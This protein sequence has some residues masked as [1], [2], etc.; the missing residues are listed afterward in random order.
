MR[1][2]SIKARHFE[3]FLTLM[4]S[5]NLSEAA[6]KLSISQPGVS[7]AIR[8]L[9]EE[10]GAPLF[11]RVKGR[12]RPTA[13][14]KELLPYAQRA[15]G[16]LDIARRI[17]Y[18]LKSGSTTQVTLA[19]SAPFLT[20]IV[21]AAIERLCK[22][23]GDV[24]IEV[25][26]ETTSNVLALVSN[27]DVDIGLSMAPMQTTDAR[28]IEKCRAQQISDSEMVVV[29]RADHPLASRSTIRP[30]DLRDVPVVGLPDDSPNMLHLRAAF[31][32]AHVAVRIPVV[33][34]NSIGVCALVQ[35]NV[36]VGF[37]NPL[38]LA[39]DLFP[40]LVARPFRPRVSLRTFIY[41]S[42]YQPLTPAAALLAKHV[43][44]VVRGIVAARRA[45]SER[46]MAERRAK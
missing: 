9:E 22:E 16:Q 42:A 23:L 43:R 26:T 14:A 25:R 32:Q 20:S 12:L 44:E 31:Q 4:T 21:P 6:D 46:T 34:A 18:S 17:A 5:R 7:K 37:I 28:T 24:R 45:R 8:L 41:S 2:P 13:H 11:N 3:I 1:S 30:T 19:A 15:L 33:V 39:G 27:H 38:Q 36:G 10:S 40:D 35:Q 29:L